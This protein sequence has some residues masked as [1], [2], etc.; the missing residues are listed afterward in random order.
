MLNGVRTKLFVN[1]QANLVIRLF[2][3]FHVGLSTAW[4]CTDTRGEFLG[5]L[6]N[7]LSISLHIERVLSR[8][9]NIVCATRD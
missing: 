6:L 2:E 4:L 5:I 3:L 7:H 9:G 8:A 1:P